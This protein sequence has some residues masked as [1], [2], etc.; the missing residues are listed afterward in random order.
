MTQEMPY[1]PLTRTQAEDAA[2]IDDD[3]KSKFPKS[4]SPGVGERI[5]RIVDVMPPLSPE[6][7]ERLRVLLGG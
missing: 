1:G 4:R 6:T 2:R 5:V 3:W 7:R